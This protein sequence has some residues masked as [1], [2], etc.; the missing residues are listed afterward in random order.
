MARARGG[1][2]GTGYGGRRQSGGD[3]AR[4]RARFKRLGP[5]QQALIVA[6]R[7]FSDDQGRFDRYKWEQAFMSNEPAVIHQVVGVT[8]MFERLVNHLNGMLVAGAR[9]TRLPVTRADAAPSAPAVIYAVRNDGGLTT[10]QAEVLIRL[11]RTRNRLQHASIDLHA[12]ELHA[13]IELLVKTLKRLAGSYVT[14]L[15][16]HDVHLLPKRP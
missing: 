8:G 4:I 7:P 10:N 3:E 11:N 16:H 1:R 13:D 9:L 2:D 14:W 5:Q 6:L 12:D 15:A